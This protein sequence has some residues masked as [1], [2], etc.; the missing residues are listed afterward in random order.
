VD[1]GRGRGVTA[2]AVPAVAVRA[3]PAVDHKRIAARLMLVCLCFFVVSGAMALAM[4]TELGRPGLQLLSTSEYDQAFTLHGSGMVYL[5]MTPLALALGLYLVPLQIGANGLAFPAL[6]VFGLWSLVAGGLTMDAGLLTAHGA[7]AAGWTAF[8]PLSDRS[9]SPGVGLDLWAIGVTLATLS[10]IAL[11]VSILATIFR[12]RAPGMAMLQM[13]V[14]CWTMLVTCLM[15]VTSFPALVA[16]MAMI[17]AS[18]HLSIHGDPVVYQYLFWF[19]GHPAVYVMF[20]PFVGAVAE[21]VPTFSGRR[22]FGYRPMVLSLLAFAALSMSVWAHHMFTTGVVANEYFALTSTALA[23]TAG[24]EYFDLIAT[25][26][27]GVVRFATP[28]LFALG[29]LLQFLI[30]G[31]TGIIVASPPLNYDLNDSYFVVGHFHYTLFAGSMFGLLAG[32]YYWFPKFTGTL[33]SERL[34]RIQFVLTVVGTNLAFF[35]MLVLGYDGMARRVADYP[36][37]SGFETWN[38]ISTAGAWVIALSFA[39][40]LLNIVLSLARGV[41]AG[42]DPWQAQTLEWA[43]S[44]PP[45]PENFRRLPEIRSYAPLLDLRQEAGR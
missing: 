41:P 28:M 29:F 4:R 14:F 36:A 23:I 1:G 19:Y 43:T 16:A 32:I 39:V 26:W 2:G 7:A 42:D 24:V 40:F 10:A 20:F 31:L 8:L 27:Q 18:R 33:L 44:S 22:F 35:P 5:V 21:V 25:M 30:G 9:Y 45:P 38:A 34:G 37:S 12:R 13:P 11:S 3:V 17:A 15:V 6:A